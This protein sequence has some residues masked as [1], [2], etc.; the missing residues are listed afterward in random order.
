MKKF[1]KIN[2]NCIR[3]F[4]GLSSSASNV[5]FYM[6]SNVWSTNHWVDFGL[7]D[8]MNFC[9][10]KNKS[11]VYRGINQL[12]KRGIIVKDEG[13]YYLNEEYV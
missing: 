13:R 8:C 3:K 9:N 6:M 7:K 10:Y 11:N 12:I 1:I 2:E 4:I 5:L